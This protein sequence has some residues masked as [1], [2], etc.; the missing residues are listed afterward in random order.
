MKK[1]SATLL[2]AFVAFAALGQG[3]KAHNTHNIDELVKRNGFKDI[4]LGSQVD[5]IKG[6]KFDEDIVELK[7]FPA[8]LY[9]VDNPEYKKVGDAPIDKIEL[10]VYNGLIYEII[11]SAPKDPRLMRGLEKLYGKPTYS[12]RTESYYWQAPDQLSL[13]YKGNNKGIKLFYKSYPV[14]KMM[15]ADKKKKIEE[16]A[17]DF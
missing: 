5:S 16:I 12:L 4:K 9:E 17:E 3:H 11:V 8:K 7:E 1:H 6:A 10:K 14:I 13:V 2:L 15:Y